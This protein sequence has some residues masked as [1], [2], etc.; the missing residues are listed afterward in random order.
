VVADR[1]VKHAVRLAKQS[2]ASV[3][4][5][6]NSNHFG[7]AAYWG[8]RIAAK[9]C[10]GIMTCNTSPLVPPWQGREARLGTNPICMAVPGA[11]SGGWLLDMATTTVSLGKLYD[12]A[13][14]GE[15][16]LPP[17]WATD[18]NGKPTTDPQAALSGFPTPLGG[19]KGTGLAVM[20]E[21]LSAV[22]SGGPMTTE[23]GTLRADVEAPRRV[24]QMFLAIEAGRFMGLTEF[25][26]RMHW[27]TENL[28]SAAPAEG[29]EEV[30]YA[31]EPEC[32]NE[33][34]RSRQGI[35]RLFEEL[36]QLAKPLGV[37]LPPAWAAAQ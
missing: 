12:A 23:V 30:L 16:S 29:F 8:E 34:R 22:L 25:S 6:R 13:L 10:I 5:A 4:V 19:Y 31:N 24:S 28:K 35:P 32:R 2:G 36:E 27:L 3:V 33:R 9:G 20:G 15:S 7:A 37:A 17:G 18:K 21:I 26:K 11:E 1:C 14:K